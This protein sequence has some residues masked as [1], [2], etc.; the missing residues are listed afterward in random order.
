MDSPCN[1]YGEV[2]P[3]PE[4]PK[5]AV[6]ER[7]EGVETRLRLWCRPMSWAGRRGSVTVIARLELSDGHKHQ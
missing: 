5:A 6:D 7:R 2:N 1:L 3:E 4:F